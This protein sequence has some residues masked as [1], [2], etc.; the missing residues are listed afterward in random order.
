MNTQQ[1]AI[2]CTDKTHKLSALARAHIQSIIYALFDEQVDQ[3]V[4]KYIPGVCVCVCLLA[5]LLT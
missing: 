5:E 2:V 1:F 3:V 4:N